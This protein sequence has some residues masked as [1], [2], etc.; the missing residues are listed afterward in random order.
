MGQ[1]ECMYLSDLCQR[2]TI[3]SIMF[4]KGQFLQGST[5]DETTRQVRNMALGAGAVLTG[6]T[7]EH[8]PLSFP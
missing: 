7:T 8:R 1:R 6:V 5:F 3:S 2:N 4:E